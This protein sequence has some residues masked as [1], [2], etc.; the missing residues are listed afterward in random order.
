MCSLS[1]HLPGIRVHYGP[2]WALQG[3][4]GPVHGGGVGVGGGG[5]GAGGVGVGGGGVGVG[6]GGV[7]IKGTGGGR[8]DRE[9]RGFSRN[10][11]EQKNSEFVR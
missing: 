5:V 6:A 11:P 10:Q 3:H 4:H 7:G 9:P 2:V 8:V 1:H